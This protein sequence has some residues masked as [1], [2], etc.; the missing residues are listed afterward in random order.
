MFISTFELLQHIQTA[1]ILHANC[2]KEPKN[3]TRNWDG[4]TPF[5][6]HPIWCAVTIASEQKLSEDVRRRGIL[7]LLYHDIFEDTQGNLP[8]NLPKDVIQCIR[9]MTF[10]ERTPDWDGIRVLSAE[11]RLFKLYDKTSNLLDPLQ[12]KVINPVKNNKLMEALINDVQQNYGNLNIVKI[13]IA[14]I[15]LH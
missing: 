1:G 12:P 10:G 14:L 3:A 9:S 8:A 6:I 13:A 7:T 5:A 11:V 4:K 15:S 2:P